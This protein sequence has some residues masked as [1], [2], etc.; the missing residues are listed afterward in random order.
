MTD[1]AKDNYPDV[2]HTL[3]GAPGR[4]VRVRAPTL[5]HAS[6]F[7]YADL[8][9]PRLVATGIVIDAIWEIDGV[10]VLYIVQGSMLNTPSE[11]IDTVARLLAARGHAACVAYVNGGL[12]TMHPCVLQNASRSRAE[13]SLLDLSTVLSELA[14]GIER[15][16]LA[17]VFT[18]ARNVAVGS[19]L[20]ELFRQ[21]AKA[22][23]HE[24]TFDSEVAKRRACLALIGRAIF[25]RFLFDRGILSSATAPQLFQKQSTDG[26][27]AWFEDDQQTA[28]LFVWLDETFNGEFLPIFPNQARNCSIA[29]YATLINALGTLAKSEIRKIILNVDARS[30]A[31]LP[32]AD[33]VMCLDYSHIPV[34]LLSEIYE[35]FTHAFDKEAAARDSRHYTPRVIASLMV[36]QVFDALPVHERASA[37]VLDPAAGA[38]VFLVL[39]LQ[40]IVLE[41]CRSTNQQPTAEQIRQILYG[42]LRGFD[43][44]GDAL[45]L[46][47]LS[48]Y[49]AAVELTADPTPPETLLFPKPLLGS[50]LIHVDKDDLGS[51]GTSIDV[52]WNKQFDVVIGNP[53]WTSQVGGTQLSNA[54]RH[55][56]SRVMSSGDGVNE[57]GYQLRDYHAD[58][59][60]VWRAMEWAKPGAWIAFVLHGR[61][62]FQTSIQARRQREPLLNHLD[63][64]GILNAADFADD[65]FIWPGIGQPFCVLFAKNQKPSQDAAFWMQQ[66]YRDPALNALLR[67]RLDPTNVCAFT[68]EEWVTQPWIMKT[69]YRGNQYDIGIIR[70]MKSSSGRRP[71][72]EL[73][74]HWTEV[75][76]GK[77]GEGFKVGNKK[78]SGE[79]LRALNGRHLAATKILPAYIDPERLEPFAVE[80]LEAA[81][82]FDIYRP[83]LVVV[84][85]AGFSLKERKLRAAMAFSSTPIVYSESYFGYS[86]YGCKDATMH[87][88]YLFLLSNSRLLTY[89]LLMTDEKL[90]AER[91]AINK[92]TFESFPIVPLAGLTDVERLQIDDFSARFRAGVPD[93]ELW[94]ALDRWVEALY[95]F[96]E[97]ECD[98]ISDTLATN[99]PY[100]DVRD[101]SVSAPTLREIDGF[102]EVIS[103]SINILLSQDGIELKFVRL[104][105]VSNDAWL[106]LQA[107]LVE[108]ATS[109]P[110]KDGALA[111][112]AAA[113]G[114]NTGSSHAFIKENDG[115]Y[116]IGVLF[117]KRFLTRTKARVVAQFFIEQWDREH[118][119]VVH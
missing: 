89:Y 101:S 22:V 110:T 114:E 58:I 117:Q 34:G 99:M 106:F 26:L 65:K 102:Q 50:V 69:A 30:Q 44:D 107:S 77:S 25:A 43:K 51:L 78:R 57:D 32:F 87:L 40:R 39:T 118:D 100:G 103:R 82:D 92:A 6:R 86:A 60:F 11:P 15:Q 24:L 79:A 61:F 73:G 7:A 108:H 35:D 42:Q 54:V 94:L 17:G 98:A 38:G 29:Q 72:M 113:L 16:S 5:D 81:R 93:D 48:L 68:R 23:H 52:D 9:S 55:I 71:K 2:L 116:L 31:Q 119:A 76:K 75:L 33:P 59:P 14:Q 41:L 67:L 13:I 88:N 104:N 112:L 63:V 97:I 74:V 83:P 66:M 95:G 18:A 53:P 115:S 64:T 4:L 36:S 96:T 10:P 12:L 85:E 70:K 109:A 46:A 49:L 45:M 111:R 90:G 56:A 1:V 21:V 91:R 3:D 37:T 27:P 20:L 80:K 105:S 19:R 28:E 62:L 8:R 84:K 47:T